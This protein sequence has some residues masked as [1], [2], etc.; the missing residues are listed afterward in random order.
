MMTNEFSKHFKLSNLIYTLSNCI[1]T[2][3][4][5]NFNNGIYMKEAE[6]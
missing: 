3:N 6:V 2:F 4:Y 5:L 1:Y